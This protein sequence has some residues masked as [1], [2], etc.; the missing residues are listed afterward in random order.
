MDAKRPGTHHRAVTSTLSAL[1]CIFLLAGCTISFTLGSPHKTTTSTES[2]PVETPTSTATTSDEPE[3]VWVAQD[4]EF[5][6]GAGAWRTRIS[7]DSQGGFT[8]RF[9]DTNMGDTGPGYP[10]GTVEECEFW[11]TFTLKEIISTFEYKLELIELNQTGTEGEE[12]I[13]DGIRYV[14]ARPYGLDPPGEFILY[15]AGSPTANMPVEFL[16]WVGRP[17]GWVDYPDELP[18]WG[19]YNSGDQAGFCSVE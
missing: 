9:S 19:L 15:P 12:R 16:D 4:Y 10:N 7:V 11:G 17:R 5:S 2:T 1:I 18:C 8:G 6:S 13:V 14:T 3:F